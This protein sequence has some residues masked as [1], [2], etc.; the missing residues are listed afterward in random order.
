MLTLVIDSVPW[1]LEA[2]STKCKFFQV[3]SDAGR[4]RNMMTMQRSF[5]SIKLGEFNTP[6]VIVDQ[7]GQILVWILPDLLFPAR[8]V[9]NILMLEC[10]NC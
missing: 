5:G 10:P 3:D 4:M 7:F 1:G 9:C 6:A 2:W 8:K